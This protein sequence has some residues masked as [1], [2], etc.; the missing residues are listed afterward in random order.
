MIFYNKLEHLSLSSLSNLM[1]AG[2]ATA[3]PR[4]KHQ[5]LNSRVGSWPSPQT[6]Q[7]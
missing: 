3:Y 5:V 1:F 7:D 2:K 6:R 4:V